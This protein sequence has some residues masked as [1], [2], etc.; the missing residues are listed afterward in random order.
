MEPWMM[1]RSGR[2]FYF[3]R[4]ENHDFNLDDIAHALSNLCRF[5]GHTPIFYSV[6]EHSWHVAKWV[7]GRY[8]DKQMARAAL[9]HDA[10]EAYIGDIVR[11]LKEMHPT[12]KHYEDRVQRAINVKFNLIADLNKYHWTDRA[13]NM[14]LRDE[15]E[16]FWSKDQIKDWS[17]AFPPDQKL[18]CRFR[19]WTPDQAHAAFLHYDH[20]LTS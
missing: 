3:N 18:N 2:K 12:W 5:G 7:E 20:H 8:D 14:I 13:D 17:F 15:A 6:A 16:Y 9:Y 10:A 11:P 4:P 1:T 19:D